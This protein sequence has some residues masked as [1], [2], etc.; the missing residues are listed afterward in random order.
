[1][2]IHR[3]VEQVVA[4]VSGFSVGRVVGERKSM[5][6]RRPF[7]IIVPVLKYGKAIGVELVGS[8][9]TIQ[10]DSADIRIIRRILINTFR[11]IWGVTVAIVIVRLTI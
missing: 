10:M 8:I 6:M 5:T 9:S 7:T 4:H 11:I 3:D 2:V 1:M